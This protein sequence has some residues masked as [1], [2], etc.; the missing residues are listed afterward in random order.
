[1]VVCDCFEPFLLTHD[2]WLVILCMYALCLENLC[3]HLSVCSL[4]CSYYH[5]RCIKWFMCALQTRHYFMLC[6]TLLLKYKQEL[7]LLCSSFYL[8]HS[9]YY[10]LSDWNLNWNP[11]EQFAVI[12]P[13][14]RYVTSNKKKVSWKVRPVSCSRDMPWQNWLILT[15]R[16]CLRHFFSRSLK[17]W[18]RTNVSANSV[19]ATASSLDFRQCE[20]LAR[21]QWISVLLDEIPK[22]ACRRL[23]TF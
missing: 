6:A 22:H 5:H 14:L 18:P 8:G 10:L 11:W 21:N 12:W 20:E 17:Q 2:V 1:M 13:D 15:S 4:L 3:C 19:L 23:P 9:N 16:L 7:S